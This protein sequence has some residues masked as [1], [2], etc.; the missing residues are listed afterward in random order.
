MRFALYILSVVLVAS[1]L[2]AQAKM[3]RWVDEEGQM[4]FGDEIPHEY[5]V[6]EHDELNDS[7]AVI[8]HKKAAETDEQKAKA[9]RVEYERRKVALIEKKKKQRDRVLLDT[10]TTKRD[11][12]V[13]R[14]SRLEAV[15]SQIQLA[16]TIIIDSNKKVE[17]MDQQ[18]IDIKASNREV[19]LDLYQR[20]DNEKEQVKVQSKVKKNYEKRRD[21][22]A[23]QFNDYIKRFEVLKAE[24]KAKREKFARERGY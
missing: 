2:S 24:Q 4:H 22:I 21:E 13:A 16:D 5:L 1:S 14:D 7:G 11:L 8:K 3:Y 17:S 15:D 19:P 18:V 9:K 6:R 20:I 23:I 12:I 10:Y